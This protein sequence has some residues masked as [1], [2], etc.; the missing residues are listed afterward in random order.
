MALVVTPIANHLASNPNPFVVHTEWLDIIEYD[1]LIDIMATGRT[2][3]TK[4]DISGCL[5]LFM[6]EIAKLVA[7][8]KRVKTGL[9]SFYLC[10]S[11]SLGSHDQAFTPREGELDHALN[12]HFRP[13]R[14]F[15]S[16]ICSK[17]QLARGKNYD[18]AQPA[19]LSA[20]S[21]KTDAPM[22]AAPGDFIRV[23]GQRLRFDKANQEEGLFFVNGHETRAVQYATVSPSLVI[24][25]VPPDLAA[26]SYLLALRSM[27]GSKSLHEGR[28]K[29][30]L[31]IA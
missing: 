11:G 28:A 22:S 16:D 7:D 20:A 8:G 26:G 19:I 31:V 5:E 24:A 18:K 6:E 4:P 14:G 10:A 29:A 17:V 9:G 3:L 21:V 13:E 25:Q 15:E 2:T 1:K 27:A 30:N 12:L 23:E